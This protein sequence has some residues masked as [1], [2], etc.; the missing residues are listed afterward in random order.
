MDMKEFLKLVGL[1]LLLGKSNGQPSNPS[2]DRE[3]RLVD[4]HNDCSGHLEAR[5]GVE[6][7]LSGGVTNC[8]GRV[9]VRYKEEWGGVIFHETSKNL[10]MVVSRQLGC[11]IPREDVLTRADVFGKM[12]LKLWFDDREYRLVDGHNNCSGHLE[13]RHNDTWGSVCEI[14]SDLRAA[15]VLFEVRLSGG[16]SNCT[17]RVE[18]RYKGEWG[19]V[20]FNEKSKNL[21]TVVSRQ[22]GCAIPREDVLTRADVF[23]DIKQLQFYINT[24]DIIGCLGAFPFDVAAPWLTRRRQ[25]R[26]VD[27]NNP[28]SGHLE[29][30]HVDTW[31]SVCEIDS[32]LRAANVL[33]PVRLSGGVTNCTGRVEV[34]YNGEWGGVVFSEE[35]KYLSTVVSRQL[36]CAIPS[37]DVLTRADEF[38]DVEMKFWFDVI[39]CTGEES[40][41]SQ[42]SFNTS[43]FNE[44]PTFSKFL[45]GLAYPGHGQYRLVDG[46][47]PCSGHLEARHGDTWGSVCDI[48]LDL[49]VA[50]VLCK[51]LQCGEAVP[52][53][54]TYTRRPGPIWTEKIQCVGNESRLWKCPFIL[55]FV[56]RYFCDNDEMSGVICSAYREYRLVGGPDKCSGHLEARHGGTWGSVCEIDSDFR[57]ANVLCKELQ[58]GEAVPS[59]LTYTRRPGPIWTEKIQCVGNE[60]RLLDCP[61]IHENTGHCTEQHA[62]AIHCKGIFNGYKFI[63]GGES[64]SG[65]VV[66]L[67]EG[68]WMALCKSYWNLQAANVLCR[69]MNCGTVSSLPDEGYFESHNLT[70][71]YRFYCTGTEY[72]LGDCNT[73]ALGNHKCPPRDT[74]SIICT[75]E[76]E[77]VR[78]MGG[79][80][81]CAGRLEILTHNKTWSRAVTDQWSRNGAQVVCRE[82]HCG[83]LV[84]TFIITALTTSNG[85]V[86]LRGNC[87]GNETRLTDCSVTEPSKIKA[88]NGQEMEIEVICSE[89]KQLKLVNGPGQCAGR[90]EIYH[91]GRWG[92]ICDDSWDKADADVVCKQLGCGYAVNATTEAY[93]GKGTGDI[94]LD[95]VECV[96]NETHIW[97]CPKKQYGDHNCAHKEDAGVICS[98]FMDIRLV[99]G[100]HKCEGQLEIYHNGIWGSVCS[101]I[102]TDNSVSLICQHLNC[103]LGGYVET[104]KT[105]GTGKWPYWI[106]HIN[107]TRHNKMLLECPSS[108]WNMN[109]CFHAELTVLQYKDR[110]RLIG[111]ENICSGR[112]EVFYQG[113]WGTV[114]DDAW[115]IKDA[116]V[117]CRQIGCGSA[118]NATTEAAM[119]GDGSG[120]IW[121]SEVQCK[122]YERALQDCRSQR[123]NPSDCHHKEDAG[124]ICLAQLVTN[125][126]ALNNIPNVF[127][128]FFIIFSLLFGVA[129][130]IIGYLLRNFRRYKKTLHSIHASSNE[131][132]YE[133]VYL[134]SVGKKDP[135]SST[136][137]YDG[138]EDMDDHLSQ[139]LKD[140]NGGIE[141]GYDDVDDHLSQSLNPV[142]DNNGIENGYDDV[143]DHL[144]Q[145]IN[146]DGDDNGKDNDL[147]LS[148]SDNQGVTRLP[149]DED[150]DDAI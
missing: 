104:I 51:E 124:V 27:G 44:M 18:V 1:F 67:H 88:Q 65:R 145:S 10:A 35:S 90:V 149:A 33:L 97:D 37:E 53:L 94:W 95:D 142:Q 120:P 82:L 57:V 59:L 125:H 58:C 47:N 122:G 5:H 9:E 119:F 128:T 29:A 21:A 123:W 89:S 13:A 83:H 32:D 62:P 55:F 24:E 6:V 93:Y 30:Q 147:D 74:A 61:R 139:S 38:G 52:S 76:N 85:H 2:D 96:G 63:N 81:H 26:L 80:D 22:L 40:Y 100:P 102:M 28:C 41:L 36:G 71:P 31:G 140:D 8:R 16:V 99:G 17:G 126:Q 77:T 92:T 48:D 117:V 46:N 132:V 50:N 150:Y 45:A 130:M 43:E 69:Q 79:E 98:D 131:P 78:L 34:K 42:C 121:L 108:P 127:L 148:V 143:D 68:Q 20:L 14:D 64:C 49:R 3:Y 73:T 109:S 113:Q 118:M 129:I 101:N 138:Y 54:L 56:H 72:H 15:N 103:G 137:G 60:S 70:V 116:E 12:E 84:D 39:N 136:L 25:Y 112:V 87:Q 110:I 111:G 23:G 4:G 134:R 144:S 91:D 66:V 107:C 146:P 105:Y 7:R 11:A 75:G 135:P 115:D 141:N 19:G 114:C 86:Y 133:K 106:D